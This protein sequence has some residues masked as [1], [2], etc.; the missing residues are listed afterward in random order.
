MALLSQSLYY[1]SLSFSI[2]Y[3]R[4][5]P[6]PPHLVRARLYTGQGI[7]P[8]RTDTH[9]KALLSASPACGCYIAP[10]RPRPSTTCKI[11]FN[12]R[13]MVP[14]LWASSHS[15]LSQLRQHTILQ[16]KVGTMPVYF[17]YLFA[18]LQHTIAGALA[19]CF[20]PQQVDAMV[21]W[22][23]PWWGISF[24]YFRNFRLVECFAYFLWYE[25]YTA[26]NQ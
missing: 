15:I 9:Q 2:I 22:V 20:S 1:R 8:T 12:Q 21:C 3:A 25:K 4:T 6:T 23:L 19:E 14:C 10:T 11:T 17:F 5:C 16:K 26:G 24:G 7:W 13:G 18:T